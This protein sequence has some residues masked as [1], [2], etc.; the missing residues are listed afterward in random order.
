MGSGEY[1]N[2]KH[3]RN[4]SSNSPFTT[5]YSPLPYNDAARLLLAREEEAA[6]TG[7]GSAINWA[8]RV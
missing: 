6:A 2:R 3:E 7:S 4:V 1:E 5:P 8:N